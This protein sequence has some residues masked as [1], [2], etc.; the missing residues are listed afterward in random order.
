MSALSIER[1]P[2]GE[3]MIART[4][5]YLSL[6]RECLERAKEALCQRYSYRALR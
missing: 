5:P 4:T 6:F 1:K 2:T 3:E